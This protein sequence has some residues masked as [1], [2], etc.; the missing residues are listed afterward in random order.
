[1]KTRTLNFL[2]KNS[3]Q[4]MTFGYGMNKDATDRYGTFGGGSYYELSN[5]D[6]YQQFRTPKEIFV[7]IG[8]MTDNGFVKA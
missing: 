4:I 8:K 3:T 7:Y 5:G 1:M 2:L 6:T